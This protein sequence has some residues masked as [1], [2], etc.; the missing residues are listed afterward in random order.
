MPGTG[1]WSR[2]LIAGRT[3][4]S[5]LLSKVPTS[6]HVQSAFTT[7]VLFCFQGL[8]ELYCFD[9]LSKLGP[10]QLMPTASGSFEYQKV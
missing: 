3:S 10:S 4:L 7:D 6:T 1:A 9:T 8:R 2:N 5:V